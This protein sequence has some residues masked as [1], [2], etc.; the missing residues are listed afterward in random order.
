ML[1]TCRRS[2]VYSTASLL[3]KEFP[4][5]TVYNIGVAGH[6]FLTNICDLNAALDKYRPEYVIIDT[7]VVSF[8]SC[9]L[10]QVLNG[11]FPRLESYDTGLLRKLENSSFLRLLYYQLTFYRND[12]GGLFNPPELLPLFGN[13]HKDISEPAEP[14]KSNDDALVT[15]AVISEQEAEYNEQLLDAVFAYAA[16]TAEKYGTEIII[17]YHPKTWLD[18]YGG[19][20][21]YDGAVH[22]PFAGLCDKYG[23]HLVD[24][25]ERYI[26]EYE[27][28][29]TLPYGFINSTV[30][31]GHL[32][33]RGHVMI[34]EEIAALIREVE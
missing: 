8:D 19:M 22:T 3:E 26:A 15:D 1:H 12:H 24:M 20:W 21:V 4:D 2:R 10:E 29:Y 25:S 32:N 11:T 9:E 28:D 14:V 31:Y 30:G 18:G 6:A 13:G 5:K 23:I 27:N 34:S 17:V 16:E 7:Q 33:R